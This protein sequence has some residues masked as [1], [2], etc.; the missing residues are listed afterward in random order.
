MNRYFLEEEI[1]NQF[2]TISLVAGALLLIAGLISI[3]LPELTSL[4]ISFLIGWALVIGSVISGIHVMKSYNSKWIAWFKPFLLFSIGMLILYKP[5]TGVAAIGL[6]LMIYFLMDGFAG[7]MFGLEL[8]PLKGWGWMMANG[9]VSILIA[10]VFLV[11]WPITSVWLIG[12]LVGVSLIFD[13][14]AMI[15]IGASIHK[16]IF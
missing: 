6:M 4:T 16:N 5:M 1:R 7:I 8:R 13:G 15:I 2:R 10:F 14:I 9:L 3:F 11:G 12:V